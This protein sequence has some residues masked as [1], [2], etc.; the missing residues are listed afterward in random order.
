[1]TPAQ[2]S[3]H[4]ALTSRKSDEWCTPPVIIAAVIGAM[5]GIDL[6]PASPYPGGPVPALVHYTSAEDGLRQEWHG[7]VY[8]NPPFSQVKTWVGKLVSEY[9]AGHTTEAILL[10]SAAT[11]TQWWQ[12]IRGYTWC[13]VQGRLKFSGAPNGTTRPSALVYLG[14][15]SETF[16]ET[17]AQLGTVYRQVSP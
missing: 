1:M 13:A 14:E 15:R 9:Q 10:C 11:D 12:A 5:G 7:R 3:A 4:R 16:A 8:L 17:F 6:D 2:L